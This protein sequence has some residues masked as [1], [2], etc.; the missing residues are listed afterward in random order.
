MLILISFN[1]KYNQEYFHNREKKGRNGIY[2]LSGT[3][4][5]GIRKVKYEIGGKEAYNDTDELTSELDSKSGQ[6]ILELLTVFHTPVLV[7]EY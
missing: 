3:M 5:K 1:C 4:R 2:V 6:N 7:G